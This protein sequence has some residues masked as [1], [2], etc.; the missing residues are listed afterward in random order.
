M[1]WVSTMS[2]TQRWM[3]P[4]CRVRSATVQPGQLGT[5]AATSG[6]SATTAANAETSSSARSQNHA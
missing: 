3:V 1:A 5:S 6:A 2:V 4:V